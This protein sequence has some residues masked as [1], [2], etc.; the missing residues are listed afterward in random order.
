MAISRLHTQR[1]VP[2]RKKLNLVHVSTAEK[3]L[4]FGVCS[5]TKTLCAVMNGILLSELFNRSIAVSDIP[6]SALHAFQPAVVRRYG[7]KSGKTQY[8]VTEFPQR[9]IS[10]E[11]TDSILLFPLYWVDQNQTDDKSLNLNPAVIEQFSKT[12]KLGFSP[13]Q[14]PGASPV[15]FSEASEVRDEFKLSFSADDLFN[16]ALASIWHRD[17]SDPII[18]LPSDGQQFWDLVNTGDKIRLRQGLG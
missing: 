8:A 17:T 12:L 18:P 16:Y 14:S 1:I 15:C 4:I 9:F 7:V 6:M 11:S 2:V 3:P 10:E 13:S 5:A